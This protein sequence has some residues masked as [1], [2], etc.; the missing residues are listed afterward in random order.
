MCVT[1]GILEGRADDKADIYADGVFLQTITSP[2]STS[3]ATLPDNTRLLAV[4]VENTGGHCGFVF[5][6]S[7]GFVTDTNWRCNNTE[8]GNWNKHNYDDNDWQP[9]RSVNWQPYFG[10]HGLD[11]AKAIWAETYTDVVYCRGWPSEY[12]ASEILF[13]F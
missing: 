7:N 8:H 9:A 10:K 11:P 3:T 2:F 6:L 12:C 13:K 4:R 1:S 5:K